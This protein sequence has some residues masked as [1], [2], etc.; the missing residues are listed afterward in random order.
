[1]PELMTRGSWERPRSTSMRRPTVVTSSRS[2]PR[3]GSVPTVLS[4]DPMI[5]S[6]R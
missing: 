1:M 6:E 2:A 5:W 3:N 4:S